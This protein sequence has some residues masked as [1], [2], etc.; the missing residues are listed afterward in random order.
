MSATPAFDGLAAE[1]DSGFTDTPVGRRLRA[2]VWRRL[3]LHFGPGANVLEVNCGTGEDAL[4][5]GRRGVRVLATD[6]APAMV[7]AAREKV[8]G[9]GL[10]DLVRVEQHAIEDV[11]PGLGTFDGVLSDF[12]GLNCVADLRRAAAG[13]SGCLRPGG[14]AV[15]CV[16]GPV[17]PWEWAWYLAHGQPRRAFRRFHRGGVPWR[18][19]TIRYPSIR[20]LRSAFAPEFRVVRVAAVGALL[21]PSY[22]AAWAARHPRVLAALDRAERSAETV[23]PLPHLADHYLAELRRSAA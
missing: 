3:D 13:L 15:L 23:F 22:A 8:A 19:L 20:R 7:A 16:M 1:Y 6:I 10:A 21:P 9:A 17:V 5:L 11:G 18:D 4:H 2:A 14:V 12:G